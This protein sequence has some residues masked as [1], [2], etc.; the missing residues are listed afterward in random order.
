MR[1]PLIVLKLRSAAVSV[2]IY[3]MGFPLVYVNSKL[4]HRKWRNVD[5]GSETKVRRPRGEITNHVSLRQIQEGKKYR[6]RSITIESS[7]TKPV[8]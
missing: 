7:I 6:L 3:Y 8:L 2:I 4:K 1:Y 5:K